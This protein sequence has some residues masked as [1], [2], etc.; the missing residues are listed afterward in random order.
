[1]FKISLT[2]TEIQISANTLPDYCFFALNTCRLYDAN[3]CVNRINSRTFFPIPMHFC[4]TDVTFNTFYRHTI[5]S[6]LVLRAGCGIW[7]YRFLIIA[8]IFTFN[9]S[10]LFMCH[11]YILEGDGPV[12]LWNIYS[13]RVTFCKFFRPII[14]LAVRVCVWVLFAFTAA[15]VVQSGCCKMSPRTSTIV[16]FIFFGV[17]LKEYSEK[18]EINNYF[19]LIF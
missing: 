19:R 10:N 6:L 18:S 8:Y 14:A 17:P 11:E 3:T 2:S 13:Q 4:H 12:L 15:G 7:L 9:N 5:I 1:M 16:Q